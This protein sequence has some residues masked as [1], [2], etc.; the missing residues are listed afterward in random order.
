M[1]EALKTIV[2]D[3]HGSGT[4]CGDRGLVF[5]YRVPDTDLV[6]V[7]LVAQ[8]FHTVKVIEITDAH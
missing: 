2:A 7:F 8:Q 6:V 1:F 5:H 4:L 3:P